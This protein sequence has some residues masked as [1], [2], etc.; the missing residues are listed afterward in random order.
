LLVSGSFLFLPASFLDRGELFPPVKCLKTYNLL[1]T[2]CRVGRDHFSYKTVTFDQFLH[3]AFA[4]QKSPFTETGKG[5]IDNRLL[6]SFK[7]RTYW[8]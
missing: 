1:Y 4:P 8:L 6:L 3:P 2:A 7:A 5:A